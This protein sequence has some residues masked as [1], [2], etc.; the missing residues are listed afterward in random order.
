MT[1]AFDFIEEEVI[2]SVFAGF[3]GDEDDEEVED[4]EVDAEE[5]EDLE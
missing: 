5:E 4:D 3:M 2:T 1:Y